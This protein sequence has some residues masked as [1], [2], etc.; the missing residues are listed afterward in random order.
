MIGRKLHFKTV[1]R[2]LA[3]EVSHD[4]G[5]VN[6]KI[7]LTVARDKLF[8]KLANGFQIGNIERAD[9]NFCM[10]NFLDNFIFRLVR[11]L[12]VSAGK[13]LIQ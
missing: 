10:R 5:I 9:L 12:R 4:A 3:I 8:S 13:N 1:G 2:D 7:K 6:E 11:F